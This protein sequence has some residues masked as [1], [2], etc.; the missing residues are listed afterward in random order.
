M[1]ILHEYSTMSPKTKLDYYECVIGIISIIKA[2][3]DVI[4]EKIQVENL[5]FI[6]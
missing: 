2:N 1:P 5:I 6:S 4:I 3:L